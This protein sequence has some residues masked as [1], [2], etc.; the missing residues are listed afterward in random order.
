MQNHAKQQHYVPRKSYLDFFTDSSEKSPFC[1]VYYDKRTYLNESGPVLRK[2]TTQNL[3]KESHFYESSDKEI[4]ELEKSL[5]AI[6]NNYKNVLENKILKKDFLSKEDKFIVSLFISS[7]E[8]RVPSSKVNINNFVDNILNQVTYLEK[9]FSNGKISTIHSEL[10]A[11]KEGNIPFSQ[12][13]D[14]SMIINRWQ[15]SDMVFLAIDQEFDNLFFITSDF[16]VCSYDFT[17]M[18]GPYG[19]PPLSRTLEVVAPLTPRTAVFINNIGLNG[20]L[21]VWP[22]FIR[23]VNN[24]IMLRSD[25]HVISPK[26][27]NKKFF[28]DCINRSRQSLLLLVLDDKLSNR[29]LENHSK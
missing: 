28:K 2:I 24:R 29:Y 10:L 15:F 20:Y 17:L 21:E 18:N 7:L 11:M 6:E 3:C 25:R 9:Q 5:C 14:T 4:N 16:P 19:I 13:V 27:L 1:W 8:S 23:E 22:N 12:L 26:E